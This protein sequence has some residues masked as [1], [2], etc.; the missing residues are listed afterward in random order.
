M[1]YKIVAP[2]TDVNKLFEYLESGGTLAIP[3]YTRCTMIDNKTLQR[4]RKA[5]AWL[6]KNAKDGG[7]YLQRGNHSD[8]ISPGYLKY[9]VNES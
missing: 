9:W 8:Y 2:N 5:G 3:T 6:L 7:F 1:A 4:F